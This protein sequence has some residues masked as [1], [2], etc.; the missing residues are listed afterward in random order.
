MAGSPAIFTK[1]CQSKKIGRK[2]RKDMSQVKGQ[3]DMTDIVDWALLTQSEHRS[4]SIAPDR[5]YS[6]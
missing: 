6:T 3:A 1:L 5:A 2:R 4:R